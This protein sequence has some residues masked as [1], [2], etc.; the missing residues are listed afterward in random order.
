MPDLRIDRAAAEPLL[1]QADPA[2]AQPVRLSRA[3]ELLRRQASAGRW[4]DAAHERG[5][6]VLL[7]AA[8][9]VPTN[10]LDLRVV[11][12]GL[13]RRLVLQDVRLSDR[14]RLPARSATAALATLQRPWFAGGTV[15]F[16]T[17]QGRAHILAPREAG[18]EDGTLNYLSIPAVEIGLRHLERAGIEH[19]PDADRAA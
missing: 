12:A 11:S 4:I 2:R 6:D 7:D 18:F 9:F 3:V 17:V 8:A 14:R 1:A 13:R 16:A 10:R 19:D 15:N 5:W